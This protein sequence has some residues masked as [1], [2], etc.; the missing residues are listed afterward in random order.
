MEILRKN[1]VTKIKST[2]DGLIT[3]FQ[4]AERT[5]NFKIGKQKSSKLQHTKKVIQ[6]FKQQNNIKQFNLCVVEF[7]EKEERENL[8][9]QTFEKVRA[10][11][12]LRQIKTLNEKSK[13]VREHQA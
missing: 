9:E 13:N 3:G 5:L 11:H 2:F 10:R 6:D 4:K 1:T 12:F 7:Q 8:T